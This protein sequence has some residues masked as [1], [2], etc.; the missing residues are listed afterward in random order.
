MAWQ[1]GW[2]NLT[3]LAPSIPACRSKA[4][5]SR[6]TDSVEVRITATTQISGPGEA[7]AF[8]RGQR[9]TLPLGLAR[10]MIASGSATPADRTAPWAHGVT[11]MVDADGHQVRVTRG[12][13]TIAS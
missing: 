4:R 5:E 10:A 12:G 1:S 7:R 6:S 2:H 13:V 8:R 11:R 3:P 9:A